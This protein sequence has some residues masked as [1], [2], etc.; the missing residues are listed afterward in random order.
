[1]GTV[2]EIYDYIRAIFATIGVQYCPHCRVQVGSQTAQQIVDRLLESPERRILV[3]API[4]SGR[5]EGYEALLR[6][7]RQDGFA[8]ARVDG[9]IYDLREKAG[10]VYVLR[11]TGTFIGAVDHSATTPETFPGL[12][13]LGARPGDFLGVEMFATADVNRDNIA[14]LILGAQNYDGPEGNRSNCG[15]TFVILGGRGILA[16]GSVLDLNFDPRSPPPA[17]TTIL[18][19]PHGDP[20]AL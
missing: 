11:G 16:A 6:R 3:L 5:H 19:A 20:P 18:R 4:S 2:T 8:R 9:E 10:E 1:M 17:A 7:A 12:T 15:G 13:I 14:D